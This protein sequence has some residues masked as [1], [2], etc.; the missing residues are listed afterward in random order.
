MII[1][2]MLT[3]PVTAATRTW[4]GSVSTSWSNPANWDEGAAPADGDDLVF[5]RVANNTSVNDLPDGL[6]VHSI[7]I[8]TNGSRISGNAIVLD[9]GGIT[10]NNRFFNGQIVG[11]V[12]FTSVTLNASQSW[13]GSAQP[14]IVVVSHVNLNGKRLTIGSGAYG[15]SS[16]SGA[17]SIV[18]L[19]GASSS[20]S[21]STASLTIDGGLFSLTGTAGNV[22]V[23]N[24]TLQLIAGAPRDITVTGGGTL[25]VSNFSSAGPSHSGSIAIVAASGAPAQVLA[26][27]TVFNSIIDQVS[28]TIALNYAHLTLNGSAPNPAGAMLVIFSNDGTDPVDGTF[29]GLP[30]GAIVNA[31]GTSDRLS[32]RGGD[33]NDVT[34]T[35]LDSSVPSTTTTVLSSTNPSL[36]NQPVTLT[37]TVNASAGNVDFFDGTFR[38]GSAP[39]DASGRAALTVPFGPGSHTITAA[40]TGTASLAT[41]QATVVQRVVGRRRAI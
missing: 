25:D 17:G 18:N 37:A 41:S 20:S 16:L 32:Y 4:N 12:D 10:V 29:M 35:V 7:A 13:S 24:G 39:L 2:L 38:I 5:P 11:I 1:A 19:A 26:G 3:L 14:E 33:G 30:E 40:Y 28:G 27:Y 31:G 36:P 34:L 23:N 6:L 21:A 15:L 8:N 9:A 22:Q